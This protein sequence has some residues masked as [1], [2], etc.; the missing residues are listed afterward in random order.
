[1][2]RYFIADLPENAGPVVITGDDVNHIKNVMRSKPGD[3]V[4]LCNSK[5]LDFIARIE[6]IDKSE[7]LTTVVEVLPSIPEPPLRVVLYQGIPKGDKMDLII[8]KAVEL[9]VSKIVP[10]IT[11]RSV[12]K[13]GSVKDA[14]NKRERWQKIALEA[15]KQCQRGMVP[16]IDVPQPFNK[17]VEASKLSVLRLIPYENEKETS[18]RSVLEGFSLKMASP[19][20]SDIQSSDSSYT[21]FQG[22]SQPVVSFYIG[23]EGGFDKEEVDLAVDDGIQS[24]SLG[25]RILRTE[26]AGMVV[27]SILMY[28]LG[29]LGK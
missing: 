29:D 7:V 16:V 9:G 18:I 17:A 12:V 24:I 10:V 25:K 21:P 22:L 3:L 13:F 8:Q 19:D 26:T 4:T 14:E 2:S 28:Q 6:R 27:L 1:M 20:L 15:A 11:R 23:P 5:G